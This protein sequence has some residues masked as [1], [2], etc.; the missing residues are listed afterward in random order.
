MSTKFTSIDQYIAT[1]PPTTQRIL[2]QLRES[3]KKTVPEA[4]EA[5]SYNIPTFKLSGK[6][7]VH[8]AAFENHL[9]LYAT[10]TGHAAFEDE[11]SK[12]KQGKGSVQFPLSEP[13]PIDL[14]TRIVTFRVTEVS[15]GL[16]KSQT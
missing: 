7:L 6:N 13:L 3:I 2:Q 8:F 9:G 16:K 12:Y 14:I 5:I 15:A 1:F 4:I 11:L 10:P